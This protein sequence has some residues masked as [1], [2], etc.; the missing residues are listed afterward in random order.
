M[1]WEQIHRIVILLEQSYQLIRGKGTNDEDSKRKQ[2]EEG[3]RNI[4]WKAPNTP[5]ANSL[6]PQFGTTTSLSGVVK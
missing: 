3:D 5:C 2:S 4:R 1:R 6:W